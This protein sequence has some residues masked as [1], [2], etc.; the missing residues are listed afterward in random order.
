[1]SAAESN[2][3]DAF[4]VGKALCAD[5]IEACV[6]DA[7]CGL[8]LAAARVTDEHPEPFEQ[9][10][11]FR[12]HLLRLAREPDLIDGYSAALTHAFDIGSL[13]EDEIVRIRNATYEECVGNA[14]ARSSH[15]DFVPDKARIDACIQATY[16]IEGM[17][18]ALAK[19]SGNKASEAFPWL[20]QSM[21]VR[22]TQLNALIAGALHDDGATPGD[23]H[24]GLYG[25]MVTAEEVES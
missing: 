8:L 6:S 20:V 22:L 9:T 23:L 14:P 13:D 7:G 24:K 21:V 10:N 2:K 17:L 12:D 4:M 5:A 1:M 11:P 16:Q 19:A 18:E 15:D 3:A 25:P